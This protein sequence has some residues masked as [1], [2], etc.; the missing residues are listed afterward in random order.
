MGGEKSG[1]KM[2]GGTGRRLP[3]WG[4]ELRLGKSGGWF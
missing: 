3:R 4:Q 1:R 2:S